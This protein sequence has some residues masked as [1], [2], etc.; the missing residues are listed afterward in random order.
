MKLDDLTCFL[1][2][3]RQGN[4]T[5]AAKVLNVAQSTVSDRIAQLE[6][7]LGTLLFERVARERRLVLT[8]SGKRLRTI[9]GRLATFADEVRVEAR[10]IRSR[11]APARLGVNE[12]VAH[13]WL[14]SWL[15]RLRL[16]QPEIAFDLKVGTTDELD[17]MMVGGALDLAIGTRGFGY[18]AIARREL[19]RLPMVFVGGAR[20]DARRQYSLAELAAQGLVTFQQRSLVQQDLHELL[21]SEGIT[22]CRIDTVSSVPVMLRLVEDGGGVATLPRLLVEQRNNPRLRVLRC[23]TELR[24][25]PLWLSWRGKHA[26]RQVPPVVLSLLAFFE[27]GAARVP[28]GSPLR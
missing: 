9:A 10:A 23:R 6:E 28:A 20:H 12:S 13:L 2:V 8:P 1:E 22:N 26:H 3:A 17:A 16:E 25:V 11:P 7:F 14:G 19:A 15:A 18:R 27:Q 5:T 21:R 24:P 4:M